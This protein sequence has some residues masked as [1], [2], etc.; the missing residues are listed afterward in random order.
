MVEFDFKTISVFISAALTP[1]VL[2]VFKEIFEKP[3][4]PADEIFKALADPR[5]AGPNWVRGRRT[6]VF[7]S[8]LFPPRLL[9]SFF[10]FT[11]TAMI[12]ILVLVGP[13]RI[14]S[15]NQWGSLAEP[16]TTGEKLLYLVVLVPSVAVYI[17]KVSVPVWKGRWAIIR[18]TVWLWK[19]KKW[20]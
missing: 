8:I 17:W 3:A 19:K 13:D 16:L 12:L 5:P 7:K 20:A 18:A 14:L 11:L 2:L 6:K 15:A 1:S 10:F 4:V 9:L